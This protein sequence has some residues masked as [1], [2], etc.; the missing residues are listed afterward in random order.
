M[1]K[2][3]SFVAI[4]FATLAVNAQYTYI[5]QESFESNALPT[6]W[7]TI[8]ADGDGFNWAVMN[9]TDDRMVPHTGDALVAS[10]SYDNEGEVALT[11]DNWLITTGITIP[12]DANQPTLSWWV[13]GQDA[14]WAE[15]HYAVYISTSGQTVSDFSSAAV[16]EGDATGEYVQQTVNLS[17]FV[18]QTIYIAFRHYNI[19][20]M[21]F[22]NIDDIEVYTMPTEPTLS[23]N[24]TSIDFGTVV[25]GRTSSNTAQVNAF[26]LTGNIAIST[27]A[28][29]AVSLDGSNYN[30]SVSMPAAGGTL[31]VQFAPTA[32]GAATGSVSLTSGSVNQTLALTGNGY[33]CSVITNLPY[34]CTFAEDDATLNCWEIVD[35]NGDGNS[36]GEDRGIFNFTGSGWSSDNDG[37]AQYFYSANN[38]ANDWLISPEFTGMQ[39]TASFDYLV[40]SSTYPEE[41]GV[42]VIPQGQTYTN[43]VEVIAPQ[44][45]T[46]VDFERHSI[47]L[48]AYDN[49]VIRIGIHVTSD[50]NM[51]GVVIDN[52]TVE[53]QVGV[54][55]NAANTIAIYPNPA[56]TVLNVN[57]EGYN[58]LEIVNLLGQTVY[59][60]NATSNMQ[61]NV[62][63]L[64]N[65]VYF[66][67]MNGENG[68]ATQKFI[69]K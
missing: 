45:Y 50:A 53:G 52:F 8:D 33:A 48:S 43:A 11:P 37:V 26:N 39:M 12:A 64:N 23:V 42:Y 7:V 1:R 57:A 5:M 44:T 62:S 40:R 10:A 19:T 60:A 3:L 32:V 2:L 38:Q 28:P 16:Y 41:F 34:N 6:G 21:F 18:G 29:F 65:G 24:P 63:N 25:T 66:V 51:Y 55:E 47:D 59:T 22:L 36:E 9:H 15:E 69:K 56:T 54:N 31:Y 58:T 20:N 49:Q 61:I 35:V 27:Q 13:T 17:S 14:D 4:L 30:T 67:R 46:N 68:T